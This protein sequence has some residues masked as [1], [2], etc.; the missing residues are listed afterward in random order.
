MKKLHD[1]DIREP[2]FTF[3]DI[4]LGKVRF[5]EEM[6]IGRSRADIMMVTDDAITGLEIKSDVDSFSRLNKQVLDY[7]DYFDYNYIVIGKRHLKCVEE[8]IPESWGVIV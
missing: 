7:D 1:N 5:L 6:H 3:F 2:L 8:H 4:K